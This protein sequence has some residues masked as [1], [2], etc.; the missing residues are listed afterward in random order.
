MKTNRVL[1]LVVL[2]A[3]C[4]KNP[5]FSDDE[6]APRPSAPAVG[7]HPDELSRPYALGTAVNIAVNHLD[8]TQAATYQVRSDAPAILSV[9]KITVSDSSLTAACTAVGEGDTVIHLVDAGGTVQRSAA[10]TVRAP[11]SA[12]LLGHGPLRV[13]EGTPDAAAAAAAEDEVR[14]LTGGK[15]VYAVAYSRGGARVYGRGIASVVAAPTVTAERMTSAGMPIN[16]WIFVTPKVAGASSLSLSANG[17]VLATLPVQAVT[18]G[19][20]ATL[21]LVEEQGGKTDDKQ[22]V[23]VYASVTDKSGHVVHGVYA[24]WSLDGAPQSGKDDPKQTS[25]DLYRYEL[26]PSGAP[27]ALTATH[28]PRSATASI[29]AHQGWVADTTY[30]GCDIGRG[31]GTPGAFAALA[32]AVGALLLLRKRRSTSPTC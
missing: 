1:C 11:D 3:G 32:C 21:A 22:Q 7:E 4:G 14:V 24:D 5:Y 16:E 26:D 18:E 17:A 28:G 25:G 6:G 20:L 9:G 15:G 29:R 27:R 10:I 31:R 13:V 30:L 8:A 2:A 19:D 23:W 12:R